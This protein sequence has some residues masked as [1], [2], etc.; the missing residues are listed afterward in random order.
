MEIGH[1]AFVR[2]SLG[3]LGATYD[4]HRRLVGKRVVDFLLALIELFSLGVMAEALQAIIGSKLAISLQRGPVD[5]KFQVEGVV[6]HEP[7]F[8]EN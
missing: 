7:F 5:A 2:P 1:F 6:P 3:D 4:N 8:S